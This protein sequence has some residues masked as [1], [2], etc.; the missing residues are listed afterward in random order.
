VASARSPAVARGA[1]AELPGRRVAAPGLRRRRPT[2]GRPRQLSRIVP[3]GVRVTEREARLV[4]EFEGGDVAIWPRRR[5]P[6]TDRHP[7]ST[8][9]PGRRW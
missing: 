6:F 2:T 8:R 5:T 4:T 1:R 3:G 7:T 9:R